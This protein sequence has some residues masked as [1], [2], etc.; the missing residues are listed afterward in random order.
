MSWIPLAAWLAALVVLV[1]V[2]GFCAYELNWK[3]RRLRTDLARLQGLAAQ[4]QQLQGDAAV[5]QQRLAR[6]GVS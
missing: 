3:A 2:L 1:V 5:M 6:A 4:L